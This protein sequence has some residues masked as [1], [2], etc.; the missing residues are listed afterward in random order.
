MAAEELYE[1]APMSLSITMFV[2]GENVGLEV[3]GL[4]PVGVKVVICSPEFPEAHD[5][6]GGVVLFRQ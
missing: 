5:P 6:A 2:T 3:T 4:P 1:Y